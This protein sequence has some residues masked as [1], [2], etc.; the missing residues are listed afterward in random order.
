[1]SEPARPVRRRAAFFI[2]GFDPSGA[3]RYRELY[4]DQGRQQAAIS[5]YDLYVD[6]T[7]WP[8][9]AYG[10]RARLTED[11][12]DSEGAL[13]FLGWSDLVRDAMSDSILHAYWL[14]WRTAAIYIFSGAFFRL[15]ALRYQPMLLAIYPIFMLMTYFNIAFF[16]S[17]VVH[18][19]CPPGI[20]F[21]VGLV[22]F[23]GLMRLLWKLDADRFLGNYL[24]SDFAYAARHGGRMPMG[25]AARISDWADIV[26]AEAGADEILL[27]GHSSGAALAVHVAAELARRGQ[28]ELSLLTLGHAVPMV[29][30]LPTATDLRRDLAEVARNEAIYWLDVTAPA[31]GACFALCDPVAVSGVARE[32]D[33]NPT[34]ISAAYTETLSDTQLGRKRFRFFRKHVQYMCAFDRPGDY[35]YFRI[36]AG[37]MT[38]RDRFGWRGSS[39]SRRTRPTSRYK[40]TS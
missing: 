30:F 37:A 39:A 15:V 10:W 28:G 22:V 11:G 16:T 8:G 17:V 3:R 2:P 4:R 5:G 34:V 21:V 7:P 31:D 40:S 35:D 12:Q 24:M 18:R 19:L 29:S 32:G 23:V 14:M 1:M 9:D 6:G 33:A 20:D 26:E 38:L 36:T 13:R 27:I 25:L